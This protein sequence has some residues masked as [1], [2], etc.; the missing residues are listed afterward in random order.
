MLHSL[1]SAIAGAALLL[2][3]LGFYFVRHQR[4][5]KGVVGPQTVPVA[6]MPMD[7][8]PVA[9]PQPPQPQVAHHVPRA[10]LG[11]Y[12]LLARAQPQRLRASDLLEWMASEGIARDGL[13]E[14]TRPR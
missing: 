7:E 3:I 6:S 11:P 13:A 9:A 8:A 10:P 12:T 14:A 2:S 4:K 5:A 1:T